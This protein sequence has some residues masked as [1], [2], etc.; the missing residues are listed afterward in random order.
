MQFGLA[1]RKRWL[2][3]D[4]GADVGVCGCGSVEGRDRAG[5]RRR[6]RQGPGKKRAAIK[7]QERLRESRRR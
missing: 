3:L 6:L 4:I 2:L 5:R 1:S 7:H